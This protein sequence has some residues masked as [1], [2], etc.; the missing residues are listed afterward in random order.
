MAGFTS[1]CWRA[2]WV[3][4]LTS[5]W[6]H[7]VCTVQWLTALAK[8]LNCRHYTVNIGLNSKYRINGHHERSSMSH[9]SFL[10]RNLICSA[11][12]L[13]VCDIAKFV[14]CGLY[15]IRSGN[16]VGFRYICQC[17]PKW[18][19]NRITLQNPLKLHNSICCSLFVSFIFDGCTIYCGSSR[20][21]E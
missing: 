17:M 9:F 8:S 20:T 13:S 15:Q 4:S 3:E 14:L 11:D 5:R 10:L 16:C 7:R 1:P 21:H 18:Q 2:S 19:T 12:P 6:E